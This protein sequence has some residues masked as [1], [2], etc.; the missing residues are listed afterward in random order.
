VIAG[1]K[2]AVDKACEAVKAKGAKRALIL[3]VSA[4][5][6]SSLMRPAADRL[7]ERLAEL[8]LQAPQIAVL[9]NVDVAE[10]TGIDAIKDALFRQAYSPVRWVE[11]VQA[12]KS[13][14]IVDVIEGGPGKVLAGLTKRIDADMTG[15]AVFDAATLEATLAAF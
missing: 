2:A 7:R 14:G 3:P 1:S 11:S 10:Q 8:T 12:F 6:H 5:F 9:N 15:Y 13:Q 4:P